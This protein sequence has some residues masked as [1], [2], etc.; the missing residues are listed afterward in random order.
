[1][2]HQSIKYLLGTLLASAFVSTSAVAATT[3]I[4]NSPLA[5]SPSTAIKPNIMFILDDSG[6]MGWEFLP[7]SVYNNNGKY[8]YRNNYYNGVYYKD[9]KSV[10]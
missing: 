9:R 2:K 5:S 3:D 4:S 6:S 7:D 1:M 10:V 8:C